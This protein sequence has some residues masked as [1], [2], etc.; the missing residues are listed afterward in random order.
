MNAES[1]NFDYDDFELY[2]LDAAKIDQAPSDLPA[3]LGVALGLGM[4]ILVASEVVSVLPTTTSLSTSAGVAEISG[5]AAHNGLFAAV[6]ASLGL[7]GSTLWSTAAKGIAAG[8][9]SGAALVGTGQAVMRLTNSGDSSSHS[10]A[11]GSAGPTRAN[12][13]RPQSP[14]GAAVGAQPAAATQYD[15]S[16]SLPPPGQPSDDESEDSNGSAESSYTAS[17]RYGP[18]TGGFTPVGLPEPESEPEKTT[19]RRLPR[20]I[21]PE[22]TTAIAR[23]PLIFDDVSALY[24]TPKKQADAAPPPA[25]PVD[26]GPQV[27]PAELLVMRTKALAHGRTL[28]GQSKA[29]QALLEM[30]KFRKAVGERNFGVDELLLRIE[31]LATL[32]RA[33]E[34]QADVAIVERLAPNS[35]ALRQAQLLARSRFVR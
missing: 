15:V 30:N 3:R 2:L 21:F 28:L 35:P 23:Y 22:K 5:A 29:A 25:A 13:F 16:D 26:R 11:V 17:G 18:Y 10:V 32:G 20:P 27:D 24:D 6:K 4:P 12:A 33:K 8:V 7:G 1:N 31:A 14:T 9:L 19:R 34:A